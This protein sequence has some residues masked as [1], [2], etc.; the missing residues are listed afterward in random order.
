MHCA[1][2]V[3]NAASAL[4]EPGVGFDGLVPRPLQGRCGAPLAALAPPVDLALGQA[5]PLAARCPASGG[6][7]HLRGL[8][9][10]R[11][12]DLRL[13]CLPAVCTS[14][15]G[16][17]GRCSSPVADRGRESAAARVGCRFQVLLACTSSYFVL[18]RAQ[19]R[20]RTA[21]KFCPLPNVL[22]SPISSN[23]ANLSAIANSRHHHRCHIRCHGSH[24]G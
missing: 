6:E 20:S 22:A 17:T 5:T 21:T 19:L 4:T 10:V 18:W 16:V 14:S 8:A 9:T 12:A 15:M 24:C 7:W 1:V 23:K 11:M 2:A 3:A 13:Q